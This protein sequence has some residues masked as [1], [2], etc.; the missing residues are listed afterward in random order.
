M[1]PNRMP[2]RNQEAPVPQ[3]GPGPSTHEYYPLCSIKP[4]QYCDQI[5]NQI[6]KHPVHQQFP[7]NRPFGHASETP[8]PLTAQEEY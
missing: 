7:E 6:E 8:M 4:L 5:G 2:W 1:Q 3:K